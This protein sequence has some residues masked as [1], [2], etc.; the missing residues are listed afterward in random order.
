MLQHHNHKFE[1]YKKCMK[2]YGISAWKIVDPI[3]NATFYN[4]YNYQWNKC[5]ETVHPVGIFVP[6]SVSDVQAAVKCGFQ[7]NIQLTPNSGGHS[8]AGLSQGTNDSIILDFRHMTSIDI[9]EKEQSVAIGPG[10]FVGHLYAKLWKNGG[11]GTVMGM[12]TT[13]AM[14]G[15]SIGGGVGYFSSLYGLVID[16]ILEMKLVDARGNAVTANSTHNTDL[17]WAMRGVGPGYV[18]IVTSVTLKM[19]KAKDHKLTFTQVRYR[20]KDFQNVIGNFTNW[21]DWV[22]QNE[23]SIM[24]VINVVNG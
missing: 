1:I 3:T 11:W 8:Y 17:W 19:F 15:H 12:C 7:T 9:N 2:N 4:T 16:N 6:S 10:V 13:V 21:L 22:K 23:P 18:G 20:V 24:T 5:F 14:G